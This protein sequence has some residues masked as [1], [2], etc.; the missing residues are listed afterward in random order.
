MSDKIDYDF[1]QFLRN[2]VEKLREDAGFSGSYSDGGAKYLEDCIAAYKAGAENLIPVIWNSY[3]KEYSKSIDPEYT[4]Y[5][6]L[7]AKFE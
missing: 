2:K 4:E 3:F 6:R 1:V 5:L 7:K